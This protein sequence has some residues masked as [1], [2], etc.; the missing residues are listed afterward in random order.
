VHLSTFPTYDE[1]KLVA[2]S[3]EIVVQVSSKI[4]G[5]I[6]VPQNTDAA[7]I[8]ALALADEGVQKHIGEKEIRKT[9][10]VPGKLVNFIVG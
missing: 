3:V 5:K 6:V 2:D 9:I 4:R 1:A 10:V 8:E 7:T